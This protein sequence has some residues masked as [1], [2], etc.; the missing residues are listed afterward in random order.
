MGVDVGLKG[1]ICLMNQ[2][3]EIVGI[4]TLPIK[5]IKLGKS[6]KARVTN[7]LD[8]NLFQ[9]ILLSYEKDGYEMVFCI[10]ILRALRSAYGSLNLGI[11]Y[12]L[13][14]GCIQNFGI[15]EHTAPSEWYP[16]T[17]KEYEKILNHLDTKDLK[18]NSK[19]LTIGLTRYFY[20][21]D[22]LL[23]T[24]RSRR[25]HDG[26]ADAVWLADFLRRKKDN[27]I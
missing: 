12:G 25:P 6:K 2:E 20:G 5:K 24:K 17:I 4:H 3:R 22:I 10:E 13:L 11:N 7:F 23:A 21:N 27:G 26:I 1:A 16:D 15:V 8:V 18:E 14:W 19:S 9:N